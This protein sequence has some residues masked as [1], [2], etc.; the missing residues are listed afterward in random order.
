MR[1]AIAA[2]SLG[3]SA[4][5]GGSAANTGGAAQPQKHEFISEPP[6]PKKAEPMDVKVKDAETSLAEAE[7]A[8]AAAGNDCAQL[9]KALTS[10]NNATERLCELAKESGDD[11][12]C[13][14]AKAKLDAAR[15]KVKSTCGSC[16]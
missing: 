8:F 16:G 2:L 4:C 6:S 10:M 14:D 1:R 3:L 5:G 9:C 12:R 15:T 7:T 13:T 11:Q